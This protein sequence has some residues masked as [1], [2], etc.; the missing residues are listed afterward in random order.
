MLIALVGIKQ[1]VVIVQIK[2]AFLQLK[3]RTVQA[4]AI[5]S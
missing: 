1:A 3:C 2:E 5:G 4:I